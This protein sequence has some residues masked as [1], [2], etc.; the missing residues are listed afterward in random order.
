MI[1]ELLSQ[2]EINALLSGG[3]LSEDGGAAADGDSGGLSPE[4]RSVLDDIANIF[5]SSVA[6]VFGMLAGKEVTADIKQSEALS[7]EEFV[8]ASEE[9][10]FAFRVQA[11][12]LDDAPITVLSTQKCA[13]TLADLMMGGE[14]TELPD[15][16]G[17]LYLNA[18]QEGLSQVVGA[19]FTSMS[20]LLAGKRLM[21]ENVSSTLEE[22]DDWLPFP[23]N[24]AADMIWRVAVTLE[25]EGLGGFPLDI[26]FPLDTAKSVA[27]EVHAAVAEKPA[28]EPHAPQAA[29]PRPATA[30]PQAA[31]P[32]QQVQFDPGMA[33]TAPSF[34]NV[35]DQSSVDVRPAEFVPLMQ[36]GVIGLGGRIELVADIPVR[37]T[38][39]LGRTRKNI[40]DILSMTPGSVIELDKMAGEPVD[41]LVNSKLI[42]KGEVVVIDE[43]FGVRITEIVTSAGRVHS[44]QQ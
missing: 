11:G 39:E 43:N 18:A 25:I 36:R 20:S 15:E 9:T 24:D 2:S 22:G 31:P 37:V 5:S 38:V 7:Q 35:Y 10:P 3:G 29:P 42:A 40:A 14:G 33:G 1:D 8:A 16:A 4:Q 28:A 12:G 34:G 44:P 13:L 27:D 41:V 23:S 6:S 21:P 26:L 17:E 30:Q 19:A 32:P